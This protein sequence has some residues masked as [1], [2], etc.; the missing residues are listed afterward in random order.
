MKIFLNTTDIKNPKIEI[1]ETIEQ[2]KA[3]I[4]VH[5][6]FLL[7]SRSRVKK[8]VRTIRKL[9]EENFELKKKLDKIQEISK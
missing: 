8:F 6:D 4:K 5:K 2:L 1:T 3:E 7:N 9:Q